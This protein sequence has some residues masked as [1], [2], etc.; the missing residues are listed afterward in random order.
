MKKLLRYCLTGLLVLLA[1]ACETKYDQ[2]GDLDGMWQML[3]WEDTADNRVHADKQDGIYYCFQLNLMKIWKSDNMQF[4]Y[5]SKFTHKQDSLY[6]HEVYSYPGDSVRAIK[7]M[8]PYGVPSGGKFRIESLS[9][10]K[11]TLSNGTT[12]LTFRKY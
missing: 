12:R 10:D 4:Y 2:N 5:L 7:D 6:I 3:R 1:G 11:M 8:A 9:S